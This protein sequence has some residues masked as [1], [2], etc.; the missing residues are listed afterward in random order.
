MVVY[1]FNYKLCPGLRV[2]CVSLSLVGVTSKMPDASKP[3]VYLEDYGH[4]NRG[5]H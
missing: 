4:M 3:T 2:D 5:M 1:D